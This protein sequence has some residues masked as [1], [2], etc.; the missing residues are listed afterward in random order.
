MKRIL[1]LFYT[2]SFKVFLLILTVLLS[3]FVGS[4]FLDLANLYANDSVSVQNVFLQWN[5]FDYEKSKYLENE[6]EATIENVL[7]YCLKYSDDDHLSDEFFE[8]D[9]LIF[10]IIGIAKNAVKNKTV[11]TSLINN[12][13]IILSETDDPTKGVEIDGKYYIQ[14]V[15]EE[16]IT[17][18]Y[19]EHREDFLDRYRR[20][21][22]EKYRH[23]ADYLDSL[24]GVKYAVVNHDTDRIISNLEEIDSKSTGTAI[25]N[26][27]GTNEETL[28]IVRNAKNPYFEVGTMSDYVEHVNECAMNYSEDFDLYISFGDSFVFRNDVS[29]YENLHNEMQ[30][31]ISRKIFDTIMLIVITLFIMA[32]I[33]LLA[34]KSEKGGKIIPSA[35]DK[36]PNDL[37]LILNLI[38]YFSVSGLY[39]NTLYMLLKSM[40][41]EVDYWLGSSPEFYSARANLCIVVISAVVL[42]TACTLKRQYRLGTLFTNTYIYRFIKSHRPAKEE[43]GTS[44]L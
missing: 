44:D 29:H 7:A 23:T 28:L 6:I 36:L 26:Y 17:L 27:F 8:E 42:G 3:W 9:E 1:N 41:V 38:I 11:D 39:E 32:I 31:E 5:G 35:L 14:S 30:S 15:N 24:K 4:N 20:L 19:I 2:L 34:G 43:N 21:I 25:R 22:D 37:H 16:K 12:G 18:D 13:Y 33:I 40:F 10:A